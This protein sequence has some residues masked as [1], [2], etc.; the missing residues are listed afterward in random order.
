MKLHKLNVGHRGA[1][2][3]SEAEAVARHFGRIRRRRE[4][5]TVSAGGENDR[6]RGDDPHVEGRGGATTSRNDANDVTH[7]VREC[8]NG[9]RVFHDLDV[10]GE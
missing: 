8:V 2:A 1:R 7:V 6:A 3:N 9:H 10:G 4:C 5:L